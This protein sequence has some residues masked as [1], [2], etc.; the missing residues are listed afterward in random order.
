MFLGG[1]NFSLIFNATQG[2]IKELREN[3]PLKVFV[4]FVLAGAVVFSIDIIA[5][6]E[7]LTF[8]D[9]T[10]VPLFQSVSLLS[11]TGLVDPGFLNWGSVSAVLLIIMMIVGA[12]AGS[13]SGGAKIDRFV[14]LFRFIKNEFYKMMH[15]GA[16]MTVSFNGRGTPN[17]IVNKTL[18]FLFMYFIV[19]VTGGVALAMLGLDLTSGFLCALMSISNTGLDMEA[20]GVNYSLMCDAAKWILAFIM[21]VGRLE[22]FT[23]LL[24]FTPSFWKK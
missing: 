17:S 20:T 24:L 5:G 6:G 9:V 19:I 11:S 13:T 3:T 18:A 10:L 1:V 14:I 4:W 15:P 23:V 22:I 12:C 7:D 2:R 21:L 16:V 8:L